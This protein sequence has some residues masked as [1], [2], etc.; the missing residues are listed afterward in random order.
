MRW[1]SDAEVEL[2]KL[3]VH[4]D[5]TLREALEVIDQGAESIAFVADGQGC[6]LGT[7][8]DGDVR[9]AL[10]RGR[11]LDDRCLPETM[12]RDFVHVSPETGRAEVLDL[13]RAR[14]VGQLPVLDR[15]GRLCGLHTIG[16]LLSAAERANP[17]V[18]LA[19]GRGTR[20]HPITENLPKPMVAVA[21]R[22]ILERLVLHLMSHGVRNFYLSVNYLAHIIEDH[23]GD[24]S[25]FGCRIEYL[26]ESEPLGTG[27]PLSL[28]DPVPE[29]PVVVLN[30]DLVTQCDIGR[31]IDF[32]ERGGYIATF[33][34]R[35]YEIEIPFGVAT[36]EDHE[37]TALEEK[38]TQRMLVNAGIY[39][40][41]PD[42]VRMIP[43]NR[44]FPI[45]D[46]FGRCLQERM[47]VGAHV[48]EE[49]W[50]DVGRPEELLK[51]NGHG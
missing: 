49:E 41:S 23:F 50:L 13:M 12:R 19:G 24:G 51:A 44:N 35:P 43:K 18:I 10:L 28:L 31:M 40:L 37:L 2:G 14:D 1:G 29:Q 42:A 15:A 34:L 33:G 3:I 45:T 48:L 4:A 36:V 5:A 21:G 47:P 6:V 9:R 7:L 38:P 22:P 30:G 11:G 26:R 17:V 25:R 39:V 46:L 16:R 8:S 32:H 27:G 20:L